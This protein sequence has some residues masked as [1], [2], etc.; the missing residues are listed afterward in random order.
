MPKQNGP[1][2]PDYGPFATAPLESDRHGPRLSSELIF[3]VRPGPRGGG[4][5]LLFKQEEHKSLAALSSFLSPVAGEIAKR[6]GKKNKKRNNPAASLNDDL[7]VEILARLPVKSL[8]RFNLVLDCCNGILLCRLLSESS[9]SSQDAP[10]RYLVCNLATESWVVLP[11]SGCGSKSRVT[12]L[13][14]DPAISLHFHVF[15][16]VENEHGYVEGVQIYSL[17]GA[18]SYKESKWDYETSLFHHDTRSVFLNGLLHLVT[19]QFGVVA[20]DDEGETWW[21][22]T[23]P[24]YGVE[25]DVLLTPVQIASRIQEDVLFFRRAGFFLH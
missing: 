6:S 13:G 22:T 3:P 17:T 4:G 1:S 20:V 25:E 15:E 14:F 12:R 7:I 9:S 11:D 5:A 18:W 2:Y 21:M 24:G 8:C 10:F 23:V 16:F 19:V